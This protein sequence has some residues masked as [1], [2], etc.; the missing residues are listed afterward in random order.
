MYKITAQ[1]YQKKIIKA[2]LGLIP[3]SSG[4]LDG[5]LKTIRGETEVVPYLWC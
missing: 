1:C 2:N 4:I 5:M 3:A